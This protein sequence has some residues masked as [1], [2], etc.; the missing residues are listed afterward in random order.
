MKALR[1]VVS[2]LAGRNISAEATHVEFAILAIAAVGAVAVWAFRS[3]GRTVTG[4]AA[5]LG[6]ALGYRPDLWLRG[7]QEEDRESRWPG[8]RS[9]SEATHPSASATSSTGAESG[10]QSV[11]L[12]IDAAGVNLSPVQS[13]Q[14]HL[15]PGTRA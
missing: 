3:L 13:G 10:P 5:G 8:L 4:M 7:V 2:G 6:P 14:P 1:R 12:D 9:P 11:L 15:N